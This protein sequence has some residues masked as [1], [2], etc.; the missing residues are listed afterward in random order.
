MRSVRRG[1]VAAALAFPLAFGFA[2]VAGASEAEGSVDYA[3]YEASI[4]VAGP[5]GAFAGEVSAEAFYGEFEKNG[6]HKDGKDNDK[7]G[8]DSRHDDKGEDKNKDHD[9]DKSKDKDKD[10]GG[11]KE[12]SYA[13]YEDSGAAASYKGAVAWDVESEAFHAEQD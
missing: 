11:E 9:K 1:T 8:G 13:S 6:D 2:G 10:K 5:E 12:V 7:R 3:A 4:A